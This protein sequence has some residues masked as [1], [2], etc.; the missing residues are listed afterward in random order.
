VAG[1]DDMG[2]DLLMARVDLTPMLEGHASAIILLICH[3][4]LLPTSYSMHLINGTTLPP[5]PGPSI[6]RLTS[7]PSVTNR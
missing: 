5:D 7:S 2:N 6:S 1:Q 3:R 4:F